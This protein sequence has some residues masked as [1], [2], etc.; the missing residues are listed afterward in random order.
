MTGQGERT[1]GGSR[2]GR[3]FP[4]R[5]AVQA[6][7][8]VA[9]FLAAS[10]ALACGARAQEQ[11]LSELVPAIDSIAATPIDAGQAA[12]LSIAV[13]RGSDTL[14]IR[15]YG[16]ADLELDAATPESAIYEIGS[17][18]KQFTAAAVLLLQEDG[19]LS[20]DDELSEWLPD[21]PGEGRSITIRRLLD[22]TS[23]IKGYTEIP[24]FWGRLSSRALPRDSLVA[25]FSSEPFDFEPGEAMIYNNS[26]YFLLGLIIEKASGQGYEEFVEQHLFGAT[27]MSDSRYCDRRELVERRAKGYQ[28]ERGR[29]RP[30]NYVDHTWPYAAGSLCSTARDLAI[31]NQA[32]HGDGDGGTLLSAESYRELTTPG[33]L[34]DGTRLRYA[35]GLAVTETDG[36]RLISHGGGIFGYASDLRYYPDQDLTIAVLVNTSGPAAD[37]TADRIEELIFGESPEPEIRPYPGDPTPLLGTYTGPGRGRDMRVVVAMGEDGLTVQLG[38]GEAVPLSW[39]E[40]LIFSR[41]PIRYIFERRDEAVDELKIDQV[42]GVYVLQRR[43]G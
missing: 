29:L 16:S 30:A 13:V 32:L 42:F 23:G 31:W 5:L 39:E 20:L 7:R 27:G 8:A 37:G 15:G 2:G 1:L 28:P 4:A 3:A 21:Y 24:Q 22:H 9:S 26:A 41:G 34:A 18:T 17:V 33:A 25:M 36:R 40:D 14:V 38:A 35:K 6:P 43:D 10:L 12:G 19:K 11:D